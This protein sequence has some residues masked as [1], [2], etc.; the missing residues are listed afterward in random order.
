MITHCHLLVLPAVVT[1]V[2]E[3]VV[4]ICPEACP[5]RERSRLS[6]LFE[7]RIRLQGN[8]P[9]LNCPENTESL[10]KVCNDRCSSRTY[11]HYQ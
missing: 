9:H 8:G 10:D 7:V 2:L 1:I 5:A 4:D 6:E 11:L 3:S